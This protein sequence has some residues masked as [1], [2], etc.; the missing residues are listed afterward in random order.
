MKNRKVLGQLRWP[1][2][3]PHSTLNPPKK[4]QKQTSNENQTKGRV[5][6]GAPPHPKPSKPKQKSTTPQ[7][8][9][10]HWDKTS[11]FSTSATA[12]N[13]Q[14]KNHKTIKHTKNT[15]MHQHHTTNHHKPNMQQNTPTKNTMHV[16]HN[17]L[18][19]VHCCFLQLTPFSVSNSCVLK[20]L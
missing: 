18:F 9:Q 5:R 1:F 4:K 14:Q 2:G 3:T 11:F 19:L 10:K 6:W 13:T 17:P 20:T 15:N 8:S 16:E 12:P 7:I